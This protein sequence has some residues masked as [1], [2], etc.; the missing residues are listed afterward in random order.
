METMR[1]APFFAVLAAVSVSTGFAKPASIRQRVPRSPLGHRGG[2]IGRPNNGNKVAG[3]A[4]LDAN[5][6][7]SGGQAA[8]PVSARDG[9]ALPL[10]A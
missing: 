7:V 2:G 4:S 9:G 10:T 8:L 1:V 5:L 3:R 6:E